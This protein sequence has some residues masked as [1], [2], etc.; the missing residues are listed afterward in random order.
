MA[1]KCTVP[2]MTQIKQKACLCVV[3]ICVN[4]RSS[5]ANIATMP[6]LFSGDGACPTS[7][8]SQVRFLTPAPWSAYRD[9]AVLVF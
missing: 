4:L 9:G 2:Q 1:V 5:A 8:I 6:G 3:S 7:K